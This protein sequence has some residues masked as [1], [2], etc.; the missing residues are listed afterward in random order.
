[1]LFW[2]DG[3][4]GEWK[5]GVGHVENKACGRNIAAALTVTA[6]PT[7]PELINLAYGR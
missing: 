1:M 6:L 4:G 5:R 2:G 3:V 7:L